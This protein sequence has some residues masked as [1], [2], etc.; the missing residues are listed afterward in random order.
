MIALLQKKK[1]LKVWHAG[2]FTYR[3]IYVQT[4]KVNSYF[5]MIVKHILA[6]LLTFPKGMIILQA[7][8][9]FVCT[10]NESTKTI[11]KV[12]VCVPHVFSGSLTLDEY[13]A[14]FFLTQFFSPKAFMQGSYWFE[15]PDG[16]QVSKYQDQVIK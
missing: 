4:V 5:R 3:S 11:S 9:Q 10:D 15:D 8:I 6:Y 14:A 2:N 7:E 16:T 13:L 1:N 12:L